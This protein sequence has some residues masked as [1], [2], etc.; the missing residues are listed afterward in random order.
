MAEEFVIRKVVS[1]V[2]ERLAREEKK[3][4]SAGIRVPI[5]FSNRHVHL[6]REDFETLFGSGCAPTPVKDL[7]QPGQF[8]CRETVSL[9]GPGGVIESVRILGPF[10]KS[11]QVEISITDSFALGISPPPPVRDSGDHE[12]TPGIVLLGP[13]GALNLKKGVIVARRHIHMTPEEADK[14]GLK[15]RQSVRVGVESGR[16]LV[17]EEVLVRVSPD[18]ALDMH[19]DLDEANAAGIQPG[20]TAI[21]Y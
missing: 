5:G 11:T 4:A 2:L 20:Q 17:F 7:S 9:A 1:E 8:A 6:S 14:Y 3:G 21:I 19:V 18:Y 10:R 13:C 15:D 16:P 12:G